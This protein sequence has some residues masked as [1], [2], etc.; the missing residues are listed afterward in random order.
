MK[1]KNAV[2]DFKVR[3]HLNKN[4]KSK[5]LRQAEKVKKLNRYE[6]KI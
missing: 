5:L 1:R 2:E 6:N 4:I 3:H